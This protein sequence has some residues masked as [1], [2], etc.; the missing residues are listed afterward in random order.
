MR[1]VL[2][3]FTSRPG[4]PCRLVVNVLPRSCGLAAAETG[5]LMYQYRR[6]PADWKL[7]ALTC[8][9]SAG[10]RCEHCGVPVGRRRKSR[11]SGNWYKVHLHAAHLDHDPQNP[12]PRLA[13][14]CER[15]HGRYDWAWRVRVA[16][17]DLERLKHQMLLK[18][19]QY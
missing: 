3:Y 9:E 19:R 16:V 15:C 18:T 8:K 1:L 6:Y 13:A 5:A 11:H 12:A 17:V 10:W 14:L 4:I 7:L 2:A